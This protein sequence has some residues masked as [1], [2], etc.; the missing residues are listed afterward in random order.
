MSSG[1]FCS[2]AGFAILA[3]IFTF[4]NDGSKVGPILTSVALILTGSSIVY[5]NIR[6]RRKLGKTS[7]PSG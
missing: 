6:S 7:K 2:L 4:D 3:L 1:L 5:E